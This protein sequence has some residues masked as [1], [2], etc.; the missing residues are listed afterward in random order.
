M[1]MGRRA[2][3]HTVFLDSSQK[4]HRAIVCDEGPAEECLHKGVATQANSNR[5]R[6][7]GLSVASLPRH[8]LPRLSVGTTSLCNPCAQKTEIFFVMDLCT[9]GELFFHLQRNK[10]CE[11]VARFYFAEILLGLEYLHAHYVIYRDLKV[12]SHL[13]QV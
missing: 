13:V 12:P 11:E 6:H 9:G 3:V 7:N 2:F 5:A 1:Y 10:F 8:A 4:R